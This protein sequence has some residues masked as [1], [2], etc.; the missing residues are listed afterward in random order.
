[1][2]K[3]TERWGGGGGGGG[4]EKKKEK[5]TTQSV[6]QSVRGMRDLND[7]MGHTFESA[8]KCRHGIFSVREKSS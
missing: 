7:F 8:Q 5:N 4:G 2:Y 3:R 6:F 1:M